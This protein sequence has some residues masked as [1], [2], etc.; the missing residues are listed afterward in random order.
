MGNALIAK[1]NLED[2]IEASIIR[3]ISNSNLI[4][5]AY[6]NLGNEIKDQ[7]KLKE[8]IEGYSNAI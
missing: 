7:G 4:T 6:Y 1:G 2:S 5:D 3:A 8:A